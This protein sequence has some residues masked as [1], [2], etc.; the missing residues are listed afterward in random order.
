MRA[1]I[2]NCLEKMLENWDRLQRSDM[3]SLEEDSYRFGSAFYQLMDE[4]RD[5]VDQMGEKPATLEEVLDLFGMNKIFQQWPQP[6]QLNFANELSF[7][8]EGITPQ[9]DAIW[10]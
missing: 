6:L 2:K 7:I 4:I 5:F 10:A 3:E 1:E 8:L 9:E